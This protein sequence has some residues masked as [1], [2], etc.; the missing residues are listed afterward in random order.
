[1]SFFSG[2]RVAKT[3]LI[4]FLIII[5]V[6]SAV[7]FVLLNKEKTSLNDT[8]LEGIVNEDSIVEEERDISDDEEVFC[9]MDAKIC[10][11]GS[12]VGRQGPDCEF[13]PCPGEV[14]SSEDVELI[15]LFV[16]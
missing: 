7:F 11:D 4:I 10:P 6:V 8:S 14:E 15:E 9:T 3:R 12:Y 13:S 5:L 1:M 2:S 16:E